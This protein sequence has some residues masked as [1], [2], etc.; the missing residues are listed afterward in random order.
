MAI[1][2]IIGR[3][4][5]YAILLNRP[6]ERSIDHDIDRKRDDSIARLADTG[7]ILYYEV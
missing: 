1:L 7:E 2:G 5:V 6:K 4:R 3:Q